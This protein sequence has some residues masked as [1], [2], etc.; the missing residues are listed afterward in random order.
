MD[1]GNFIKENDKIATALKKISG[2]FGKIICVTD[3]NKKLLGVITAGDIRR[4]ILSGNDP[5]QSVKKIYNKNVSFIFDSELKNKKFSKSN[6][7]NREINQSI[8]YM[9][10]VDKKK[11]VK[12]ILTTERIIE[13]MENKNLKKKKKN[14]PK[15]LIVGGAGYIGSILC[16]KLLK[17]NYSVKIVDKVLYDKNVI[18]KFI[19]NK[20]FSFDKADICDLNT[21][22]NVIRDVDVVV[23]LAEIVGDPACNA[24]PE[25]AL[26][27]NYLSISSMAQLCSYLGISKFIYTSSCSVYGLDKHNRL[28]TEKSNLNPISH[29]AR[30]KIMSEKALLANKNDIFKPTIFRLGTV[31]GPSL[32]NRFDLVVNTMAK[33]AYY[34]KKINL[35]GGEQWRPNIHV[36]D[37]ADGIIASIK[38]NQKKV[39]NKIFNL[40][41]DNSNFKIKDI[42]FAAKKIFKKSKIDVQKSMVDARNYRVSSKKFFI[43]SGFRA[44][45]TINQA[46]KEFEK[47]FRK[48]KNFNPNKK[49]FSNIKVL[50]DK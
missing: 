39:G 1:K 24:R 38:S 21:Q 20:N 3:N 37:V 33:N 12:N 4:A 43:S 25:D 48:N 26:K 15:V 41:S 7:Y 46:Y 16:N 11:R 27:T 8:F 45:K 6:F 36:E 5:N 14:F 19:K 22:I 17:K 29:Y 13:L 2:S 32:R 34:N 31:F 49:I 35:H 50:G 44:K 40:S 42:A 47:L 28:L 10:V 23:F 9:P 18:N 30:M